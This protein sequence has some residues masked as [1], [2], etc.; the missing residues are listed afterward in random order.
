MNYNRRMLN[1]RDQVQLFRNVL[2]KNKLF[3]ELYLDVCYCIEVP[4]TASAT[5]L[6]DMLTVNTSWR[7]FTV[8]ASCNEW[9]EPWLRLN[10]HLAKV[11]EEVQELQNNSN[12]N[13]NDNLIM[14]PCEGSWRHILNTAMENVDRD[15]SALLLAKM[16]VHCT[17]RW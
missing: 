15:K 13:T 5:I 6:V 11:L 17:T 4:T 1:N 10:Q 14:I 12:A 8:H 16:L 3:Q 7:H 9:F 2:K